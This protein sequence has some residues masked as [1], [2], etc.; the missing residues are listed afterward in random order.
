MNRSLIALLREEFNNNIRNGLYGFFS[1]ELAYHSNKIEGST[2]SKEQTISLFETKAIVS[3]DA[4]E[5][6]RSKDIEEAN[7]HFLMFNHMI[8]TIGEELTSDMLKK[9][10][11]FLKVGVFED[12]A[13]GY[14]VGEYKD[15]PNFV[16]DIE[17]CKPKDVSV[18]IDKLLCWYNS[19]DSITLEDIITFHFRFEKIHPFQDGNGR[20]GRLVMFKQCL[21]NKIPPF[22]ITAFNKDVYRKAVNIAQKTGDISELLMVAKSS[23][24]SI[25]NKLY[26][27]GYGKL[28]DGKFIPDTVELSTELPPIF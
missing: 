18:E 9:F 13:N 4:M 3:G 14:K 16:G 23:Q 21:E 10:H 26:E 20:V 28:V 1:K 25:I 19:L 27:L 11:Y 17:T 6:Y 12:M 24:D 2:L 8:K 7:G 15:R 22:I 5:V